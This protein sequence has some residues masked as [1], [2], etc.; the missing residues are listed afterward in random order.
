MGQERHFQIKGR[1]SAKSL[2]QKCAWCVQKISLESVSKQ[3]MEDEYREQIVIA[4]GKGGRSVMDG[5]F[6]AGRYKLLHLK[7]ISIE[8]LLYSTGK[9]MHSLWV[10][11][12]GR[13]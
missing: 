2:R 10:E 4:K 13:K 5:E 9:Y 11:Y 7:W 3:K 1:T 6:G 8:I 12:D